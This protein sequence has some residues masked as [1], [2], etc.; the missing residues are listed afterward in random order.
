MNHVPT[1]Y[2]IASKPSNKIHK[3]DHDI[4]DLENNLQAAYTMTIFE[5]N[6]LMHP[7]WDKACQALPRTKRRLGDPRSCKIWPHLAM[8]QEVICF[9]QESPQVK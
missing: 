5:G 6:S 4:H 2:T 8:K 3:N 7:F 9:Y 1:S